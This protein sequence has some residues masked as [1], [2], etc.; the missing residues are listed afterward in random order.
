M[1]NDNNLESPTQTPKPIP[2]RQIRDIQFKVLLVGDASVGKMKI[3]ENRKMEK[4][5][6]D[7]QTRKPVFNIQLLMFDG[8]L[9]YLHEIE[10]GDLVVGDD[11]LPRTVLKKFVGFGN[12]YAL[13]QLYGESVYI[14]DG[15][16]LSL[17][18][19]ASPILE[20]RP[21]R[22][23]MIL[24]WFHKSGIM[25]TKT[26]S[27]VTK[28]KAA[29]QIE[30]DQY[31]NNLPEK[32]SVIDISILDYI[33]ATK[34]WKKAYKGYKIP[35]NYLST[36]VILD[37][38]I[39]GAWLGDGTSSKPDITS[40]DPEIIQYFRDAFPE[41][42][43]HCTGKDNTITYSVNTGV[44]G[45]INSRNRF[46]NGL[47]KLNV[48]N[49]K[50]IP[51]SYLLND[52]PTRLKLLAGLMDTDGYLGNGCYEIIQKNKRLADGIIILARSLGLRAT[53]R[54]CL[55]SCMYKGEKKVGLYHRM[56]ISGNLEEIPVLLKRKKAGHRNHMK[57]PLVYNDD[58]EF[59]GQH[60]IV[61]L[62]LDGNN[63]AVLR[64]YS[65]IK[66]VSNIVEAD[67]KISF[68]SK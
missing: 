38:Y 29:V 4:S 61:L 64:D 17:K 48:L 40:I 25:Q 41:L 6:E 46:L 11:S 47:K 52:R 12:I 37:P 19:S 33:K 27:Y 55:K 35:I 1:A 54:R 15:I 67:G 45:G 59:L 43:V 50:H 30:A 49:N 31:K 51:T 65:V 10:V 28:Q 9:K 68:D 14:H 39:L 57:D 36:P 5:E 16:M 56:F 20:D 63:R 60:A 23:S 34:T 18:L 8:S 24:K 53:T 26:F 2:A 13:R 32:S 58:I 3:L 21:E 66:F 7:E 42:D 62:E 44:R 22:N